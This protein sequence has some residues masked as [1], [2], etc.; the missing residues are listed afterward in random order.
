MYDTLIDGRPGSGEGGASELGFEAG[1]AGGAAGGGTAVLRSAVLVSMLDEIDYGL[2]VLAADAQLLL[3]NQLA[4][5]ELSGESFVRLRQDKLVP[6]SA[7]HGPNIAA[8]LENARR[9]LRSLVTL[10][11]GGGELSLSFVPLDSNAR[12]GAQITEGPLALVIFGKSSGCEALTLQHYGRLHGL[13][14]AEQALLPRSSAASVKAMAQQQ[15]VSLST[16]RATGE[17]PRENRRQVLARAGGVP[18]R[19][20]AHPAFVQRGMGAL[21]RLAFAP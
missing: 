1:T 3:A 21:M 2:V 9:G 16:V 17:R 6:S 20:P 19:P 10:G 11:G 7:H 8:A 15:R 13:T 12:S 4:R 18:D 5:R 14:G